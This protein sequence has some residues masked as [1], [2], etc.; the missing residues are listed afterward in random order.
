MAFESI[1]GPPAGVFEKL[2]RSLE[3]EAGLRRLA[4]VSREG[5]AQFR[6]RG[7][8]AANVEKGRA[9][10]V[11]VWDVYATDFTRATRLSGKE[12]GGPA[13]RDAWGAANDP[14][15]AHIARATMQDLTA[16]LATSA[17]PPDQPSA[18]RRGTAVAAIATGGG[19][20]ARR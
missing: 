10:F 2:V 6:V 3:S 15:I 20:A 11:W 8:V 16:F 12:S 14:V 13:G 4:V 9:T 18:P 5:T 19:L 1:D 17:R 7:Y